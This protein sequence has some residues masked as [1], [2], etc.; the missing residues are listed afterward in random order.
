V[1]NTTTVNIPGRAPI[2]NIPGTKTPAQIIS[3]YGSEI[4][5]LRTMDHCVNTQGNVTTIDFR[6]RTGTKG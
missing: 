6:H 3:M 5:A 4:T 2:T 1:S